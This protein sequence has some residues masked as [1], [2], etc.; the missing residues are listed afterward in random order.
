MSTFNLD[1]RG[2]LRAAW[3]ARDAASAGMQGEVWVFG[4]PRGAGLGRGAGARK[5]I[6][7]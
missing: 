4:L 1:L 5:L 6:F 7:Y 3:R 2:R